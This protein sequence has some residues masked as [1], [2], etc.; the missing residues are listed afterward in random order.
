MIL[1][2][3]IGINKG[4]TVMGQTLLSNEVVTEIVKRI[5]LERL[6]ADV[7]KKAILQV[8]SCQSTLQPNHL[9]PLIF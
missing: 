2:D 7:A 4:K 9:A 3:L 5:L 1:I 8:G 6:R